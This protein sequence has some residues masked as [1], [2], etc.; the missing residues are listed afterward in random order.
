[1]NRTS[2]PWLPLAAGSILLVYAGLNPASA[3]SAEAALGTFEGHAD[4][5]AVLHP[6][7]VE[8]DPS[9]HTYQVAGSGDNMWAAADAF[10]FVWKKVSGDVT[11]T[12]DISILGTGGEAH[13][14]AVLMIRQSLDADSAYADAALHGSGLTSIQSRLEKGG[15]SAE[16][17]SS[18]SAPKRLRIA[19]RG[20]YFYIWVAAEG[21]ELHFSGGSMRI[22]MT[23]PFYVGLGV[24]AHNQDNVERAVFS[25]V[26]LAVSAPNPAAKPLLYSTL[27]TFPVPG[28]RHATYAAPGRIEAP[29]WARDGASLLFSRNGG[30]ERVK[31]TGG[32]PQPVATGSATHSDRFHGLSPDGKQLAITDGVQ[33]N[34]AA[35]YVVP[36]DGGAPRRVT[37]QSPSYWHGWSPDGKTLVF[38][39]VRKGKTDIYT[40]PA[41]GGAEVRLTTAQGANDGAEFSPDGKYIYFNSDRA[42]SMQ[43]WRMLSDGSGQEQ[44]TSD[45]FSNWSPHLSP[46]GRRMVVLSCD[47]SATK[48]P[49]DQDVML[50]VLL[51]ADKRV[52]TSVRLVGGR[53]SIDAPSWSPDGRSL[54]FVSY[55]LIPGAAPA[56]R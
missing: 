51:L 29:V 49:T 47:R 4:V 11:L 40:I 46:D 2:L 1:M 19:K 32:E 52:Q 36:L 21:E 18:V 20:D 38:T 54:A 14:K 16:V 31:M 45:E 53:G 33:P 24:C 50:R 6:G 55:Q 10:Q 48:L 26:E 42:G 37:R 8:Y 5:G 35:I 41:E 39:G 22:H 25:N 30:I 27:E 28:D 44:V 23:E 34:R 12:A 17:Q 56:S 3:Q 7:A 9:R 15:N 13:R 43:V